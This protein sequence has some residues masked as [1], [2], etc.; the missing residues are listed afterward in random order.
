MHGETLKFLLDS[1]IRGTDVTGGR[2]NIAA[3]LILHRRVVCIS[4]VLRLPWKYHLS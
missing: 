3:G 2:V 4:F 1:D